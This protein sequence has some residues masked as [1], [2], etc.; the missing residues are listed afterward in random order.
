MDSFSVVVLEPGRK[1]G[2]AVTAAGKDLPVGPFGLKGAVETFGFA[3]GPGA[4]GLDEALDSP[5]VGD[6]LAERGGFA[7]S[8]EVSI[9]IEAELFRK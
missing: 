6:G 8:D 3:V 7:V 1:C 5:E 4:V 9:E 2:L